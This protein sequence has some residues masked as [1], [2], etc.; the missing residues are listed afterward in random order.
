MFQ[1]QDFKTYMVDDVLTK[2]DRMSMANS[3]EVR[4]PLLDHK[5]VELAFSLPL[6]LKLRCSPVAD[7]IDTKYLLKKS[8]SRFYPEEFLARR[9]QG[10]GIPVIEWCRGSLRPLIETR[11][12]DPQSE[13]FAWARFEYVQS[14]LDEF[15]AGNNFLTPKIWFLLMFDLWIEYVH[16]AA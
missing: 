8:A 12:R 11:L 13:T 4:V 1:A 10:F 9:K 6:S 14:L 3:L 16:Q 5:V 15:Y 2:V 7:R